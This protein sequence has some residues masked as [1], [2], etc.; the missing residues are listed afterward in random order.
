MRCGGFTMA[1]FRNDD[2]VLVWSIGV[3]ASGEHTIVVEFDSSARSTTVRRDDTPCEEA[4]RT[5]R[6]FTRSPLRMF[7]HSGARA[8]AQAMIIQGDVRHPIADRMLM[9]CVG[10]VRSG[11]WGSDALCTCPFCQHEACVLAGW[12][13]DASPDRSARSVPARVHIAIWGG[14]WHL[15]FRPTG[16]RGRGEPTVVQMFHRLIGTLQMFIPDDLWM[17]WGNSGFHVWG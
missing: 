11:G 2:G 6:Q 15:Q 12:G 8:H 7:A 10:L 5:L 13:S 14:S 17:A 16:T 3:Y 9:F 4:W 1:Q